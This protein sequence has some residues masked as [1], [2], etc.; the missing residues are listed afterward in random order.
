MLII[1]QLFRNVASFFKG[2]L[3]LKFQPILS[4]QLQF[5]LWSFFFYL[6]G[7]SF[8]SKYSSVNISHISPNVLNLPDKPPNLISKICL[9]CF[10]F[11]QAQQNKF[12]QIAYT[13]FIY[14]IFGGGGELEK[15]FKK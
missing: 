1:Y 9:L 10:K 7:I 11:F 4:Q 8:F 12:V 5:T 13:H 14:S 3:K 6:H 15:G 2:L